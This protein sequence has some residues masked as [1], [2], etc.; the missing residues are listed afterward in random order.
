MKNTRINRA[1]SRVR[2]ERPLPGVAFESGAENENFPANDSLGELNSQVDYLVSNLEI[3]VKDVLQPF[4]DSLTSKQRQ[5]NSPKKR[6]TKKSKSEKNREKL[7][8]KRRKIYEIISTGAV[9]QLKDILNSSLGEANDMENKNAQ[10][11]EIIDDSK[12]TLLHVAAIHE[13][14]DMVLFLLENGADPCLKNGKQYT[15]YTCMQDKTI[16]EIFK[17]FALKNPDMYNYNKVSLSKHVYF[18]VF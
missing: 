2:A 8:L 7:E 15:P 16:R 18:V 1:K 11:N 6:A 5:S 3:I 17:D 10:V 14:A 12:N 4:D 13:Q 9:T